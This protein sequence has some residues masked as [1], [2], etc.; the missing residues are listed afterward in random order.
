MIQFKRVRWAAIFDDIILLSFT[1]NTKQIIPT[2]WV[3]LFVKNIEG[4]TTHLARYTNR[5]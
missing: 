4:I 2:I 1:K 3:A 5:R